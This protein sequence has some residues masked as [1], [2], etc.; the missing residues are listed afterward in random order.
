ME[1]AE[2]EGRVVLTQDVKLL[3]RGLI[4]P[5]LAYRVKTNGKQEQLAE[6]CLVLVFV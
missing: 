6:V 1:L 5:N 2:K 4:P 3:Q